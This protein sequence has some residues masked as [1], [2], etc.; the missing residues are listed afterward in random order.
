MKK[1]C[2]ICGKPIEG[3][4]HALK[5]HKNDKMSKNDFCCD[6]CNNKGYWVTAKGVD[7]HTGKEEPLFTYSMIHNMEAVQ[8]CLDVWS[9]DWMLKSVEI[10]DHN[11]KV[12]NS[13]LC[14]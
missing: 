11:N 5:L 6:E 7:R 14:E 8:K 10:K 3:Y 9:K 13:W 2:A 4:G 1:R 12:I